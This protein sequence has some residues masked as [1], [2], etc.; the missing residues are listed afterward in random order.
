MPMVSFGFQ[1]RS[2]TRTA[3]TVTTAA[4]TSVS[5]TAK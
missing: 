4:T 2:I 5:S 3:A 1:N